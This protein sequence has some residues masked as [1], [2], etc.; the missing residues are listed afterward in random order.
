MRTKYLNFVKRQE[1]AISQPMDYLSLGMDDMD[2]K[3][4]ALPK[5]LSNTKTIS[6]MMLLSNHIT[7]VILTNG[8]FLQD[9]EHLLFVNSDQFKQVR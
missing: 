1:L 9:Q 7:G 2:Q 6:G 8:R 3:K 4:C 5:V